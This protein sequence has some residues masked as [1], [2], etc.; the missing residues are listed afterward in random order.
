[1]A[2]GNNNIII[3]TFSLFRHYIIVIIY[4]PGI[5]VRFQNKPLFVC[6]EFH[7][8]FLSGLRSSRYFVFFGIKVCCSTL[9]FFFAYFSS[10]YIVC[11]IIK[12]NFDS[13]KSSIYYKVLSMVTNFNLKLII[14]HNIH[15]VL[16]CHILPRSTIVIFD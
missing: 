16:L 13:L 10:E 7:S 6:F 2:T 9:F 14:S 12:N 4:D 5:S 3:Q 8:K 11:D 1:V 15:V